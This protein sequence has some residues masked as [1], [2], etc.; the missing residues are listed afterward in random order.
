MR[1]GSFTALP[2]VT[3]P[4]AGFSFVSPLPAFPLGATPP[5][6]GPLAVGMTPET[7]PVPVLLPTVPEVGGTPLG[8]TSTL[9]PTFPLVAP[10]A[11]ELTPEALPNPMLPE[12]LLKPVLLLEGLLNV[13]P[14]GA[15]TVGGASRGTTFTAGATP[16]TVCP[17]GEGMIWDGLTTT[18]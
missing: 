4:V 17:S 8:P 13:V 12:E 3:L 7:F 10:R 11:K 2:P 14:T 1:D 6:A 16:P 5:P 18:V 15:L 9:A